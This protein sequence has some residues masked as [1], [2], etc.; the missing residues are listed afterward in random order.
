MKN[1]F[2][3][4]LSRKNLVLILCVLG[5]IASTVWTSSV[6]HMSNNSSALSPSNMPANYVSGTQSTYPASNQADSRNSI[7]PTTAEPDAQYPNDPPPYCKTYIQGGTATCN[8]CKTQVSVCGCSGRGTEIL[9]Q[10]P[11]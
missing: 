10:N 6:G 5:I 7:K 4:K 9:C 3:T 11:N 2:S 8:Y 1:Y